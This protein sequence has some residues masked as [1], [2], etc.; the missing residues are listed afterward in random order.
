MPR[1]LE[2]QLEGETTEDPDLRDDW[3]S[4][5]RSYP[6]GT[7]PTDARRVA[8]QQLQDRLRRE[9]AG[10]RI[11]SDLSPA[12]SNA[13]RSIGPSP[14]L[15]YFGNIGLCSGRINTIAVS[16]SDSRVVL[17]GGATGGIWRSNDSGATFNP[18]SDDHVDLAVGS[19]AF[20][21]TN[22]SIVYAGMG[23]PNQPYLGTGVLK[24]IDGG[25]SWTRISN[26]SLPAPCSISKI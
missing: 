19:I 7:I 11:T 12:A 20:S 1:Q 21:K 4:F 24:S 17:I 9:A 8:W 16:P 15:P 14:T 5:Q 2:S 10:P 26:G 13:W 25:Q 3:F 23:D 6:T 22:P 18:V